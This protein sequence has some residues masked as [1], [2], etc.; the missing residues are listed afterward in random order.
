MPRAVYEFEFGY[1]TMQY[2]GEVLLSLITTENKGNV[3][4][5]ESEST[6]FTDRVFAQILEY[7]QG[8]RKIFTVNYRLCGTPFQ[9]AVWK[10]LI[11]IPYGE[12]RTYKEIASAIGHE[13]AAR[14]VGMANHRNPLHLI[15]PCHRVIGA[16]G[17]LT[18]YAGGIGIKEKLLALEK[19]QSS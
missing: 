15:I 18:G 7:L 13:K 3:S 2:E 12:T 16:D 17:S 9:R 11:N 10:E 8:K 1:I 4:F 14:A 5:E 6:E 19:T